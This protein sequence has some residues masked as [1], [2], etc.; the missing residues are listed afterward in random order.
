VL[1]IEAEECLAGRKSRAFP[2]EA[3]EPWR[4]QEISEGNAEFEEP[5]K[6]RSHRW[7]NRADESSQRD[8]FIEV[9]NCISPGTLLE[10]IRLLERR[11]FGISLPS[12]RL[13]EDVVS[14]RQGSL[15][16]KDRFG[17]WN[18]A[19]LS[20]LRSLP[21]VIVILLSLKLADVVARDRRKH[22]KCAFKPWWDVSSFNVSK[23]RLRCP[24][25]RREN[26]HGMIINRHDAYACD[27]HRWSSICS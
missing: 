2:Q 27:L 18:N 9:D 5:S 22:V 3:R 1:T 16:R 21:F 24:F 12:G 26:F 11:D 17:Y 4:D 8:K 13:P 15:A 6:D 10:H 23:P 7:K 20:L 14:C 25:F 19:L